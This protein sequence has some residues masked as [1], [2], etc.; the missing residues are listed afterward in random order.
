MNTKYEEIIILQAEFIFNT[1]LFLFLRSNI[2]EMF[3]SQIILQAVFFYSI[4]QYKTIKIIFYVAPCSIFILLIVTILKKS[5]RE[6]WAL[7]DAFKRS[8]YNMKQGILFF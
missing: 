5:L 4:N 3:I 8:Y 7:Y 2:K 6:R 1:T